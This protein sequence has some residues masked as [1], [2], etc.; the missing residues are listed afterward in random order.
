MYEYEQAEQKHITWEDKPIE[1]N[2][3]AS[4]HPELSKQPLKKHYDFILWPDN[5][6]QSL[7]D[8]N[9]DNNIITNNQKIKIMKLM[10]DI[11]CYSLS[12]LRTEISLFMNQPRMNIW[13]V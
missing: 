4:I 13:I 5:L 3:L 10:M 6:H 8:E 1:H 12:I 9:Y 2:V 7:Y 11:G